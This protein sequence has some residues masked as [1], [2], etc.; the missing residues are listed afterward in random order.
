MRL[1]VVYGIS[2]IGKTTLCKNIKT[3]FYI[4][5]GQNKDFKKI[6]MIQ[7]FKNIFDENNTYDYYI[8]EACL[9]NLNDR[10]RFIN[11]IGNYIKADFI[12]IFY[13]SVTDNF[14]FE[15]SK[16]DHSKFNKFQE[17]LN[18][19]QIGSNYKNHYII[20]DLNL[21]DRINLINNLK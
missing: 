20:N 9:Y 19:M 12:N 7:I 8:T 21:Q 3:A 4:N 10:N 15:L 6:S 1:D 14:L 17:N 13:L 18:K 2:G 5:L 16:N 11:E